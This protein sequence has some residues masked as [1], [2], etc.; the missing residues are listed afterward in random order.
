[1][2]CRTLQ[3]A[4]IEARVL[5]IKAI[6]YERRGYA[7]APPHLPE[8]GVGAEGALLD[9]A[10][11]GRRRAVVQHLVLLLLLLRRLRLAVLPPVSRGIVGKVAGVG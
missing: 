7:L 11:G 6:A 3:L 8:D 4:W 9:A 1:M 2:N 10:V 5:G